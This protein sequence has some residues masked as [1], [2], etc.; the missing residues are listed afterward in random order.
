M[1]FGCLTFMVFGPIFWGPETAWSFLQCFMA[2]VTGAVA[3]LLAEVLFSPIGYHVCKKWEEDG[4][5]NDYFAFRESL[6]QNSNS[7]DCKT[8]EA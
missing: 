4:I 8:L 1:V 6:K 5:G 7:A 3:E 2:A